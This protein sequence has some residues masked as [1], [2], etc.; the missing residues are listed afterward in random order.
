[1][2]FGLNTKTIFL[3]QKTQNKILNFIKINYRKLY[4][5]NNKYSYNELIIGN[6]EKELLGIF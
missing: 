2:V 4:Y 1:M 5:F 6:F 3:Y